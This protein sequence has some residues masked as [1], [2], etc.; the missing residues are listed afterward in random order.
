L[1][2]AVIASGY[3]LEHVFPSVDSNEEEKRR[4]EES[5]RKLL[6][7]LSSSLR[8]NQSLGDLA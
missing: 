7:F 5:K 8:S 4:G 2:S 1:R 6:L 3:A